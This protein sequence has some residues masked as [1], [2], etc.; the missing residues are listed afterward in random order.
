MATMGP[1]MERLL[2]GLVQRSVPAIPFDL[3]RQH[4]SKMFF[5]R[6]LTP[7]LNRLADKPKDPAGRSCISVE[8]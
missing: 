1:I 6:P 5:G 8:F 4:P 2:L 7:F 3:E